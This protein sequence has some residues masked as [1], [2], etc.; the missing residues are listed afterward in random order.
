MAGF[1]VICID[2]PNALALRLATR[3]AHFAFARSLPEGLIR[4]AGPFLNAEG[5]MCGSLILF[6]T[7]DEAAI[8]AYLEGDPYTQ[9]G[10]FESIEIRPW[11]LSF[12]EP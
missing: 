3:E 6:E 12:P 8:Q 2:K 4:L 9:A 10:L 5:Q 7:E 1:A 11:R